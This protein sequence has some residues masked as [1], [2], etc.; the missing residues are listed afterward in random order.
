MHEQ[1]ITSFLQQEEKR[2]IFQSPS[3][4]NNYHN[5]AGYDFPPHPNALCGYPSKRDISY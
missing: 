5:Y 3:F 1:T 2:A 4:Y